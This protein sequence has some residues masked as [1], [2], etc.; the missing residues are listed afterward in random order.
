MSPISQPL[1]LPALP[2]LPDA[3]L[4]GQQ[5]QL[6]QVNSVAE[7]EIDLQVAGLLKDTGILDMVV[8]WP[9]SDALGGAAN[10]STVNPK[11][12]A[13]RIAARLGAWS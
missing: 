5:A 8:S 12:A 4:A 3:P 9:H 6:P 1:T 2:V 7:A 13:L 11:D 10:S